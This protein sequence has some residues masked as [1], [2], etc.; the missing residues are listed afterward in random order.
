MIFAYGEAPE[1]GVKEA[2]GIYT[3][4]VALSEQDPENKE[5]REALA[6]GSV[7]MIFAYRE[8]PEQGVKEARGAYDRLVAISEQHP[9]EKAVRVLWAKG[10]V[11]MIGTYAKARRVEEARGGL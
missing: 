2:R 5:V 8:A 1:Q 10:S 6:K 3:R 9:E 4:L 11:N 7:I